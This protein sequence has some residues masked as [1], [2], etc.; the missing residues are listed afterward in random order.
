MALSETRNELNEHRNAR[1]AAV[2]AARRDGWTIT[3][4]AKEL[5]T[6]QSNISG[7]VS[8]GSIY[9]PFAIGLD[10][11]LRERGYWVNSNTSEETEQEQAR[12][13]RT[14]RPMPLMF[15][16]HWVPMDDYLR[17]LSAVEENGDEEILDDTIAV[18]AKLGRLLDELAEV[19]QEMDRIVQRLDTQ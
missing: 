6:T 2:A 3:S 9:S 14:P 5:G 18:G 1:Q 19:R 15:Q 7:I 17:L 11:W 16:S 12:A 10:A 4:L 13:V 8:R